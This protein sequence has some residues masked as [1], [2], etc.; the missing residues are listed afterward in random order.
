MKAGTTWLHHALDQQPGVGLPPVKELHYLAGNPKDRL[1]SRLL[2]GRPV[3]RQAL[4]LGVRSAGRPWSAVDRQRAGW[5]LRFLAFPR[6]D[7]GYAAMFPDEPGTVRGELTP[8]YAVLREPAIARLAGMNPRLRIVYLLRDPVDRAWSDLNMQVRKGEIAFDLAACGPSERDLLERP[9]QLDHGD[10]VGNLER[11]GR[12]F[13][14]DQIHVEF[15]DRLVVDPAGV[16]RD[17]CRFL[18]ID[19][20]D[21]RVPSDVARP[22][23]AG[24][25][26]P[27][28]EA[29]GHVLAGVLGPYVEE[30]HRWFGNEHTAGWRASCVATRRG[31]GS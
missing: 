25:T 6:T 21:I 20:R 9:R 11:W 31:G 7:R 18:G 2:L 16:F 29:T 4:R 10:Y 23:N 5:V 8:T 12:H 27:M 19:D 3:H 22:R 1:R 13:P 30:Q 28:P 24:D 26:S 14:P 15:F 17:V